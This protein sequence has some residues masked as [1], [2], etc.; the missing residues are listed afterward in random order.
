VWIDARKLIPI[1]SGE[2]LLW[3]LIHSKTTTNELCAIR[4]DEFLKDIL[5][6]NVVIVGLKRCLK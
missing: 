2:K 1:N 3:L 5:L 6:E 4:K